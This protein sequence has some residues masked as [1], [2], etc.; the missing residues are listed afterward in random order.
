MGLRL[1]MLDGGVMDHHG[2]ISRGHESGSPEMATETTGQALW[3]AAG[4]KTGQ[5][6]KVRSG[7]S[8]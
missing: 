4:A 1:I 6:T 8:E 7:Q 5:F 3:S 2:K